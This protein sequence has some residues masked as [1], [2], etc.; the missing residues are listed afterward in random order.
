[1]IPRLR[2]ALFLCGI[3]SVLA[4]GIAL[5][6]ERFDALVPCPLCLIERWP[7]RV[8]MIVSILGMLL[9]VCVIA[10]A[11]DAGVGFLHM[12]VEFHWWPSPLPECAAPNFAG[13]SAAERFAH[14]AAGPS[15]P[16]EEATYLIPFLPISMA[17][18]NMIY[19]ATL[20]IGFSIF[21]FR[22]ARSPA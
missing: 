4:L 9:G 15:K 10:F 7:Y 22:H 21:A 11:I 6:S 13:M 20:A 14:M 17:A 16:C 12:G 18:M 1:M 5:G 8:V 3:L 19:A 2:F